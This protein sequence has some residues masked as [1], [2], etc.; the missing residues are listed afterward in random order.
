ML[1][2]GTF[3]WVPAPGKMATDEGWEL[4]AMASRI[5]K[6]LVCSER[7]RSTEMERFPTLVPKTNLF[8]LLGF[9]EGPPF[10]KALLFHLNYFEMGLAFC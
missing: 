1:M 2:I 7:K 6:K 9:G 5:Q 10:Y 8:H 4:T 3:R